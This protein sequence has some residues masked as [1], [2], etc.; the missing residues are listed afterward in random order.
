[1]KIHYFWLLLLCLGIT[2]CAIVPTPYHFE[3]VYP[4]TQHVKFYFMTSYEKNGNV[5]IHGTLFHKPNLPVRESGHIDI[6]VY[7]PTGDLL[8]ETTGQYQ[9]PV[10][11][12]SA[13]S[14]TGVT[15]YIPLGMAPPANSLINLAFHVETHAEKSAAKH[16]VN[17]AR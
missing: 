16:G 17:I 2:A 11:A 15:F 9:T 6:A 7:S 10:N 4:D 5:V 1:M 13:W 12:R 14:K 3:T 8:L